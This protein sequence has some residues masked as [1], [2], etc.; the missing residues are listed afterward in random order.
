M[1]SLFLFSLQVLYLIAA[2]LA[3]DSDEASL[4]AWKAYGDLIKTY[5]TV[6]QPLTPGTDFIY[7]NPPTSN[8]YIPRQID[9]QH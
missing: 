6:N 5:I 2:T 7:V 1:G 3:V 9:H 4:I 8:L